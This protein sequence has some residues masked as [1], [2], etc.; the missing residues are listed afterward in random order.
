MIEGTFSELFWA[1]FVVTVIGCSIKVLKMCITNCRQVDCMG[2]TVFNTTLYD[3]LLNRT[4]SNASS[5]NTI[6]G[7]NPMRPNP[8][9]NTAV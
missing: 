4:S 9:L 1:G 2:F 8:L 6:G 3:H 5:S 7:I